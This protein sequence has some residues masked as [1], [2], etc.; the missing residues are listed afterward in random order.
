MPQESAT[1][2]LTY[3]RDDTQ[4][5]FYSEFTDWALALGFAW[6]IVNSPELNLLK[7]ETS[8]PAN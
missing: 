1:I 6:W 7:L 4:Q 2:A 5:A 3:E 8:Y